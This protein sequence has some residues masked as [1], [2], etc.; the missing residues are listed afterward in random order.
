VI[1]KSQQIK[2]P[3]LTPQKIEFEM[4]QE[5]AGHTPI[6][7]NDDEAKHGERF[8]ELL[9]KIQ[10]LIDSNESKDAVKN[11][12]KHI[13][14]YKI[15]TN[16]QEVMRVIS[17]IKDWGRCSEF[18][19]H[20][21]FKIKR[22]PRSP[23]SGMACW[24]ENL[25]IQHAREIV[26]FPKNGDNGTHTVQ[27]D[28]ELAEWI[29]RGMELSN[30]ST[31]EGNLKTDKW[32]RWA[33]VCVMNIKNWRI[34]TNAI[35]TILECLKRDEGP[36]ENLK[37]DE[38]EDQ[39]LEAALLSIFGK[40]HVERKTLAENMKLIAP[41]RSL[42]KYDRAELQAANEF[43][44]EKDALLDER[45]QQVQRMESV[46]SDANQRIVDLERLIEVKCSE[47]ATEQE[48][49]RLD[50]EHWEYSGRQRLAGKVVEVCDYLTHHI[51]EARLCLDSDSPSIRLALYRLDE[52]AKWLEKQKGN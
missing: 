36:K 31:S 45:A 6:A 41:V 33:I 11:L 5:E 26:G 38:T 20:L 47:I 37:A 25:L 29:N 22:K 43:I 16:G 44:K 39:D 28:V 40:P 21:H 14:E 49:R 34:R 9:S 27:Q 30:H 7:N 50:K 48:E 52:I 17:L 46:I 24:L 1:K 3:L 4:I 32:M 42:A 19:L 51:S 15:K 8:D 12:L 2:Q 35:Y 13:L 10:P 23:N 18:T